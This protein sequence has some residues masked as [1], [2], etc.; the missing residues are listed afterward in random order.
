MKPVLIT[1][2]KL[3]CPGKEIRKGSLLLADGRI[4]ARDPQPAKIPGTAEK[5]NAKGQLL[6]PGLI[7]VHTHGIQRFLYPASILDGARVLPSFGVTGFFPTTVPYRGPNL[8]KELQEQVSGFERSEGARL[9]GLHLEGPFVALPGAGCKPTDGDV[10]L[11]KEMIGACGGHLKIMSISPETP[12]ILP[13]I[14][15]MAENGIAPFITHTRASVEQ[16]QKAI[17]AG[18]RHATHFYDVFP[19]AEE[20]DPG[21]RPVG[22]VE[23]ILADPRTSVDFI[24]DGVHVHPTG[25]RAALAAKGW[26]NIMLITDSNIGAGLPPGVH[27]TT[28]GY[29]VLADPARGARI[30]DKTHRHHGMLAGSALTMDLGMRNLLKWLDLE[31]EKIW[32]M[33]TRNPARFAAIPRLG[34]LEKG[35][36]A[37][38]ALWDSELQPIATWVGGRC[39]YQK[40]S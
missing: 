38:V 24:A 2:A 8:L 36:P 28:W 39:V 12:G 19:I 15:C 27:E 35:A 10:G 16:T 40:N 11:L 34:T 22:S 14:E 3:V 5:I 29:P 21:V 26:A 17:D 4:A 33:G 6:T 20:T 32:A 7:D 13:V 9:L 37:D 25:I 23:A 18:A 1:N 31:P 30:H